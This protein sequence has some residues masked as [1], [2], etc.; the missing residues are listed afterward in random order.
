MRFSALIAG[1]LAALATAAPAMV[2]RTVVKVVTHHGP[3][4]TDF[5][6]K[7]VVESP[8]VVV[9]TKAVT[10]TA[11]R[12][13]VVFLSTAKPTLPLQ[14]RPPSIP[15]TAIS[16]QRAGVFK[17]VQP[18]AYTARASSGSSSNGVGSDCGAL[19]PQDPQLCQDSLDA[20]NRHRRNHTVPE[21]KW[22]KDLFQSA[23]FVASRCNF[24]HLMDYNGG[25]YGQNL[26]IGSPRGEIQRAITNSWYNSEV[27]YWP[28]EYYG[29]P[30]PPDMI[31][32]SSTTWERYGHFTQ[33]I[34]ADSDEVGCA[35]AECPRLGCSPSMDECHDGYLPDGKYGRYLTVCNYKSAGNVK[36]AFDKNVIRPPV[37]EETYT[38]V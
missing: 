10:V 32:P 36:G 24:S 14:S 7:H 2:T 5:V 28:D 23:F 3:R 6:N 16:Y 17:K 9:I 19:H 35:Q 34:W 25:G 31:D 33:V 4:P 22:S 29:Q 12:P 27:G 8:R 1:G 20:H 21:M 30:T 15:S 13:P 18:P 26:E 38:A 37:D 11:S